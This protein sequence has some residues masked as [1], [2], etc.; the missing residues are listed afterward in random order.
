VLQFD[1]KSD[2]GDMTMSY[3]PTDRTAGV[4]VL[5]ATLAQR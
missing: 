3:V 4:I 2:N 5:K 1:P